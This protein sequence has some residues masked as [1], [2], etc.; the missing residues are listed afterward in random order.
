M[1]PVRVEGVRRNFGISSV[2]MYT[3]TLID[4]A[5]RRI[6]NV[7]V[8]RHEALAIVAALHHLALPR[9]Q[10]IDMMAATLRFHGVSLEAMLLEQVSRSPIYLFSATLLWRDGADSTPREQHLAC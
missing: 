2:F 4:E 9:P 8:E 7:I 1:I 10:T 6:F 3:V 5:E